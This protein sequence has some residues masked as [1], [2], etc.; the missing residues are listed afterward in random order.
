MIT[1]DSSTIRNRVAEHVVSFNF[2]DHVCRHVEHS[3][4]DE[5]QSDEALEAVDSLFVC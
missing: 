4:E 2:D 1:I 5:R 3:K